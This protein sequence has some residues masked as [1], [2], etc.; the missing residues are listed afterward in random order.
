MEVAEVE[1]VEAETPATELEEDEVEPENH[2][3][4]AV[5]EQF[6]DKKKSFFDSI[7]YEIYGKTLDF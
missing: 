5:P 6:Y 3:S 4:S 2:K 1:V 7:S